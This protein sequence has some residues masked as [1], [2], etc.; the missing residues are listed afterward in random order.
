MGH[1]LFNLMDPSWFEKFY[2]T[3]CDAEGFGF[4]SNS[5]ISIEKRCYL[6]AAKKIKKI[7]AWGNKDYNFFKNN[8]S[9]HIF[10][11]P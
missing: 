5:K 1:G 6:P 7:F 11:A 9:K 10:V 4:S 8:F 2:Y 3:T